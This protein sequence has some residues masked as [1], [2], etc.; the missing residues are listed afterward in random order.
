MDHYVA[1]SP[2]VGVDYDQDSQHVLILLLTHL[3]EYP[4]VETIVRTATQNDG[5]VGFETLVFK[6][7]ESGAMAVDLIADEK[8]IRDILYMGEK[9][10]TMYWE[11]FEKDV[12]YAYSIIDRRNNRVVYDDEQKL[13]SLLNLSLI[14]I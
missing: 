2:L 12:K 7:E 8:K 6:F 3:T 4:E 10:P 13:R 1:N 11:K 9:K 5:R 14:H